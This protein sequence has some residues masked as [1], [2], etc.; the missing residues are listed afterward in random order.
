MEVFKFIQ[1]NRNDVAIIG[2]VIR[3]RCF[4][5]DLIQTALLTCVP[6]G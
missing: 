3:L 1:P 4:T 2:V 5:F 6:N